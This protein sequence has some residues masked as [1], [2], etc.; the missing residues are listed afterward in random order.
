MQKGGAGKS[1]PLLSG[2]AQVS[3]PKFRNPLGVLTFLSHSYT[4]HKSKASET[5]SLT[6]FEPNKGWG[7]PIT[8]SPNPAAAPPSFPVMASVATAG[9]NG[10]RAGHGVTGSH[11]PPLSVRPRV[12]ALPML[13]SNSHRVSRRLILDGDYDLHRKQQNRL[14]ELP[15]LS[16]TGRSR[17]R[18]RLFKIRQ[19]ARLVVTEEGLNG[20][21]LFAFT[22]IVSRFVLGTLVSFDSVVTFVR[23]CDSNLL[24]IEGEHGIWN[25][26][27]LAGFFFVD[28]FCV[29]RHRPKV[30]GTMALGVEVDK[31]Q[32]GK[33]RIEWLVPKNKLSS[34]WRGMGF[35]TRVEGMVD[36]HCS[37][38]G[39]RA[40]EDW[41]VVAS[42][43]WIAC[44]EWREIENQDQ[45]VGVG[46]ALGG[47]VSVVGNEMSKMSIGL[48]MVSLDEDGCRDGGMMRRS[49]VVE[50]RVVS[51][52]ACQDQQPLPKSLLCQDRKGD[53]LHRT[54]RRQPQPN[55]S[56][57]STTTDNH[58]PPSATVAVS[59]GDQ[60]IWIVSLSDD[61]P[62]QS[63]SQTPPHALSCVRVCHAP[64][65]R[66]QNH[67]AM[68][69]IN[70]PDLLL[71]NL[72][73]PRNTLPRRVDEDPSQPRGGEGVTSRFHFATTTLCCSLRCSQ[74]PPLQ[75]VVVAAVTLH[76]EIDLLKNCEEDLRF[77]R[78]PLPSIFTHCLFPGRSQKQFVITS[79]AVVFVVFL[80]S[81]SSQLRRVLCLHGLSATTNG[82]L[83]P[84]KLLPFPFH[85]AE[86]IF[87]ACSSE[88][89]EAVGGSSRGEGE[90]EN[91]DQRVGVGG[92]LGGPVSVVGNEMSKMSIG[93]IMRWRD[94]GK[95][96]MIL[97]QSSGGSCGVLPCL[98][99]PTTSAK[100]PPLPRPVETGL[101]GQCRTG[102]MGQGKLGLW[103]SVETGLMGQAELGLWANVESGLGGPK[104]GLW[105]SVETGLIGQCRNW[106]WWASVETGLGPASV[107]TGLMGQ[108]KLGLWANKLGLG[109][110]KLGLWANVEIGLKLGLV[111]QCKN[112]AYGPG[113][114]G[115]ME[116]E[117]IETLNTMCQNLDAIL[118]VFLKKEDSI[119]IHT[120]EEGW[121]R[122]GGTIIIRGDVI[123]EC[124]DKT[125]YAK[126]FAPGENSREI[127]KAAPVLRLCVDELQ[128]EDA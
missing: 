20:Q 37:D 35:V 89:E 119:T 116:F 38:K 98:P 16:T 26:S 118:F 11:S 24:V 78:G 59:A 101:V 85:A 115:L 31:V 33:Q 120:N 30:A 13:L 71:S 29:L 9:A 56:P 126:N 34:Y 27:N 117:G 28:W 10:T 63:Q 40:V 55:R 90:I 8:T 49:R 3:H 22:L 58:R 17:L 42:Q 100:I 64:L 45:R 39:L 114:T 81:S 51:F 18:S 91:Q 107:E 92:A 43:R 86:K 23:V 80:P 122:R 46:G 97:E 32:T 109:Q 104:L 57:L 4:S 93:L 76:L 83:L 62:H 5:Q 110:A 72:R 125:R 77:C 95:V 21:V 61:Q 111:G 128:G 6:P 102:L 7:S 121:D 113:E 66:C 67:T 106:A 105:A 99:R 74:P 84:T 53:C 124:Q 44:K 2:S 47:P 75:S 70:L 108:A 14:L 50:G 1:S 73:L 127:R 94:D 52:L 15:P 54:S 69:P 48:I 60:R 123:C 25:E 96:T 41:E 87:F 88:S 112:W 36:G 79:C 82:F 65:S 68:L 103:A 19:P 12:G